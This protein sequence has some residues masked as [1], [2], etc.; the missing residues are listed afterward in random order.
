MLKALALL[1]VVRV[2]HADCSPRAAVTVLTGATYVEF[3][4]VKTLNTPTAPAVARRVAASGDAVQLDGRRI[5]LAD[6]YVRTEKHDYA[7]VAVLVG[8][9]TD[10]AA[11]YDPRTDC[12]KWDDEIVDGKHEVELETAA[13]AKATA[14]DRERAEASLKLAKLR[15]QLFEVKSQRDRCH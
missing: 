8:C 12:E 5:E 14:R 4:K 2:A 11:S 13:L 9:K 10:A 3:R 7:N 1:A 15:V 6:L